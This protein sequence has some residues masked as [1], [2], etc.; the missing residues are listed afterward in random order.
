[1]TFNLPNGQ[2]YVVGMPQLL[3]SLDK[4]VHVYNSEISRGGGEHNS[5]VSVML[6]LSKDN[7]VQN[8][9]IE[10]KRDAFQ[11]KKLLSNSNVRD[12]AI[13]EICS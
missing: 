8:W 11:F 12:I 10:D 3:N 6:N 9:A 7:T 1:M 5:T 2:P 13:L 4:A